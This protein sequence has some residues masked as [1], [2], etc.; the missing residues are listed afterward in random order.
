MKCDVITIGTTIEVYAVH[1]NSI[2]V[3]MFACQG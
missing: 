2:E 3:L 1:V